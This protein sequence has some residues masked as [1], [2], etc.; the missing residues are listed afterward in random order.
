MH[1]TW[2][3]I[4]QHLEKLERTSLHVLPQLH[5][6]K[7]SRLIYAI[8]ETVNQLRTCNVCHWKEGSLRLVYPFQCWPLGGSP[9][10]VYSFQQLPFRVWQ[11]VGSKNAYEGRVEICL[12]NACGTVCDDSCT[13]TGCVRVES[14]NCRERPLRVVF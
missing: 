3:I 13:G 12:H 7:I 5:H 6:G 14:L 11:L 10:L 1:Q 9:R 4:V 8:G 2:G